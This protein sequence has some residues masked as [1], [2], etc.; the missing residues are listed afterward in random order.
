MPVILRDFRG[1]SDQGCG[2]RH[3]C[4]YWWRYP[5]PDTR[6]DGMRW[7]RSVKTEQALAEG[8]RYGCARRLRVAQK[9][10]VR[11]NGLVNGLQAEM[12][13]LFFHEL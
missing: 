9:L 11:R 13:D 8:G 4:A 10:G 1:R 6:R 12:G 3:Q 7:W 5:V 2:Y